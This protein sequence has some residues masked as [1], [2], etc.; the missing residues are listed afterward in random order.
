MNESNLFDR[1]R[2]KKDEID[3]VKQNV[4]RHLKVYLPIVNLIRDNMHVVEKFQS[5]NARVLELFEAAISFLTGFVKN[6]PINQELISRYLKIFLYNISIRL[7][8]IQLICEIFRDNL[9]LCTTKN[10]EVIKY[11]VRLIT[12]KGRNIEYLEFF[13][14]IQQVKNELIYVN[15]KLIL[16]TFLDPINK[17][18]LMYMKD[19]ERFE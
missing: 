9:T 3:E 14:I 16:D 5:N 1:N 10:S 11:L 6:N 17:T 12:S 18:T 7:G 15:Q 4:F 2:L 8:Q 13:F 19:S